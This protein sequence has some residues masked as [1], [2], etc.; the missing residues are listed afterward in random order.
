VKLAHALGALQPRPRRRLAH[1][2]RGASRCEALLGLSRQG[3]EALARLALD[4][5]ALLVEVPQVAQAAN[6]HIQRGADLRHLV[7]EALEAGVRRGHV[8]TQDE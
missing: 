7:D 3:G 8:G 6:V 4:G 2:Q 5:S 1:A